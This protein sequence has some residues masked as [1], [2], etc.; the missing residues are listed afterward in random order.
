MPDQKERAIRALA[1]RSLDRMLLDSLLQ[2]QANVI[3]EPRGLHACDRGR[4]LRKVGGGCV[5]CNQRPDGGAVDATPTDFCV[6]H[7]FGVFEQEIFGE[8]R[9]GISWSTEIYQMVSL[10]GGQGCG[11]LEERSAFRRIRRGFAAGR[12]YVVES[13][14]L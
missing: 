7:P 10:S 12:E 9:C 4:A 13:G 14:E 6:I 8:G 3:Q 11:D 5:Q 2:S 1:R